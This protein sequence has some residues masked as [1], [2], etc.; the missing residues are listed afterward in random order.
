MRNLWWYLM[1][2][3]FCICVWLALARLVRPLLATLEAQAV[4]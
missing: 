2:L 4:A 1:L 3:V